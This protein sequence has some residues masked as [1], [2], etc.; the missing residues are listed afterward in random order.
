ME[1]RFVYFLEDDCVIQIAPREER[2]SVRYRL[3]SAASPISVCL[4]IPHSPHS[5]VDPHSISADNPNSVVSCDG[6]LIA[7]MVRDQREKVP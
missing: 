5:S 3:L 1:L 6:I 7:F 4:V 2:H